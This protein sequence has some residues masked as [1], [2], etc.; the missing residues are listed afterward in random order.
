MSIPHL[1]ERAIEGRLVAGEAELL[2]SEIEKLQIQADRAKCGLECIQTWADG[3]DP[4]TRAY[5][6]RVV[7]EAT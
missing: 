1:L 5:I 4:G 3:Q 2:R 7:S 6:N